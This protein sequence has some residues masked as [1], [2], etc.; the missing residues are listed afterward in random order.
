MMVFCELSGNSNRAPR[1]EKTSGP[2]PQSRWRGAIFHL[3]LRKR[4]YTRRFA[5]NWKGGN[6]M[7]LKSDVG[8]DKNW[9]RFLRKLGVEGNL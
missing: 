7:Q 6:N 9:V 8:S 2:R 3:N 1:P 5:S 4:L